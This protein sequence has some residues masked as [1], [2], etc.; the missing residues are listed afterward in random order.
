M[1]VMHVGIICA[2]QKISIYRGVGSIK[3]LGGHQIPGALLDIEKGTET[4][5]PGNVGD[6]RIGGGGTKIFLTY[7]TEIGRFFD[8][9][10]INIKI[11]KQKGHF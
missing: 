2:V 3:R 6:G 4:I 7:H 1:M 11:S 8:Q 10:S 9:I 5:S